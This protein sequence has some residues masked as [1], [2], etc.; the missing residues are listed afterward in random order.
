MTDNSRE[1]LNL[2]E[3]MAKRMA[4]EAA[5][6]VSAQPAAPSFAERVAQK[7]AATSPA[8]ALSGPAADENGLLTAEC[9]SQ[10]VAAGVTAIQAKPMAPA[11]TDGLRTGP[12]VK[13][14][15]LDFRALR[16]SGMITPDNMSS[17]LS[18][19]FRGIK[20]KLLQRVRDPK[21]RAAVNNLVMITSSLPGE[22][23]TFTSINLAMSL[24]AER[25]L[26]VLLVDADVIRPAVGNM[27]VSPPSE[28]LTDL[29]SGKLKQVSDVL[30]HCVDIPNLSVIFSGNPKKNSAE[31]ISSGQ[32]A[33]LCRELSARYPD[34]VIVLDTPPVLASSE[35]AILATY[36][37]QLIMVVSAAQTDK[38]ELRKAL[39]A[40][41]SCQNVSLLFNKAPRWNETEYNSYYGYGYGAPVSSESASAPQT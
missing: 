27:F 19:E 20:R 3:R 2:V 5:Q 6:G 21:T 26:R 4:A 15:C 16:Q 38:H 24:A 10:P 29:L 35:P 1:S 40:V 14:I 36:V 32:M 17:A 9:Q 37:H 39:E 31:L 34:R 11:N 41:S 23:K 8:S 7:V 22:G 33:N 30:H 12:S 25:G 28:G 13:Q 18:N